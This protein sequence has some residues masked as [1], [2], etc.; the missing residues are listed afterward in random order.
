MAIIWY[1]FVL[2]Y[3]TCIIRIIENKNIKYKPS[4]RLRRRKAL[5]EI[6]MIV[7]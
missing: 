6:C 7:A 5:K 4:F 1:I 2:V 3:I